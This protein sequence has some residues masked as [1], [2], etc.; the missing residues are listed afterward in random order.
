MKP[1][2]GLG[3]VSPAFEAEALACLD[4]YEATADI[5]YFKFSQ[6][7]ADAMIGKFFDPTSGGFFD[8]EPLAHGESLGVLS[9]RRKPLQDSPTISTWESPCSISRSMSRASGSS[10]TNSTRISGESVIVSSLTG[11]CDQDLHQ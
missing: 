3:V 5:S 9:T 1:R 7:I 8:T 6:A 4:A 11:D 2:Q 10:S